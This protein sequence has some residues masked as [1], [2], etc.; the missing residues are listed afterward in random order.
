MA[1]PTSPTHGKLA[2]IYRLRPNGFKGAGLN[3]VTWGTGFTGAASAYYEVV[4]DGTGTP[5]TFKWRKNG[6]GWTTGVNITGAAQ[7]LDDNQTITFGA[8]TGHTADDQ[9]TIGNL[10]DEACT[11]SGTEAQITDS[12]KRLLNAN[13]PPTWTDSGGETVLQVNYTKGWA[14]FTGNVTQVTVTGNNGFAV[15]AGLEPVGFLIGWEFTAEVEMADASRCGQHW[16]EAIPGQGGGSGRAEAWFI[17]SKSF[18]DA[19]VEGAAGGDKYCLVQLF[20]YDPDQDQTGDHINVWAMLDGFNPAAP[21]GE[22]V[23]EAV[24]FRMHGSPSFVANV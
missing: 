18:F 24:G 21:I 8:T 10:K 1:S 16:K 19:V 2:A 9:W 6:G 12:T 3:D 7:T 20:I 13:S 15:E 4:I 14:N 22:P 17:G 5:D 23:R 11:E